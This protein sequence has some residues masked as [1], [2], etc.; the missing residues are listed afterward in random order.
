MLIIIYHKCKTATSTVNTL[1]MPVVDKRTFILISIVNFDFTAHHTGS[2][3]VGQL[4]RDIYE[5]LAPTGGARN[6]NL[7]VFEIKN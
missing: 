1:S 7:R 6:L 2:L 5:M 4:K 3:G